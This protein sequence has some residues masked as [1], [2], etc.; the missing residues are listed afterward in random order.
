MQAHNLLVALHQLG[1]HFGINRF[2][3]GALQHQR[4]GHAVARSF[5]ELALKLM[6]NRGLI[7]GHTQR[8]QRTAH[9]LRV[10]I[11]ETFDS[12]AINGHHAQLHIQ[13]ENHIVGIIE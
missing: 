13:R 5:G 12:L 6:F 4:K 9:Q 2:A 10:R 3:I 1:A 7:V 8:Q 11:A